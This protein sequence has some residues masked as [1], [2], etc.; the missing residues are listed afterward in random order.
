MIKR[1]ALF[2]FLLS[3]SSSL[4][5]QQP[6]IQDV[7][8]RDNSGTI[9]MLNFEYGFQMPGGDLKDRFGNY[10]GVGGGFELLLK[11]NISIS[12]EGTLHFGRRVKEDVL[13]E[14]RNSDSLFISNTRLLADVQLRQR[15]LYVGASV[16]KLWPVWKNNRR[17]GIKT[18]I[19]LGIFQHKIRI[20]SDPETFVPL[21]SGEY[22]KGYDRLSN[23]LSLRE[24]IGYQHFSRNRLINFY[25]G[26]EF[27][28][29]FT[30][31]RR[32][33]DFATRSTDTTQRT[34]LLWG[35]KV[36]WILPFYINE[37]PSKIYY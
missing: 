6:E 2:I 18:S 15:A 22:L 7:G 8:G 19:G 14:L 37:D 13:Q 34:D 4:L 33:F 1:F 3:C 36:G 21:L 24:F 5:A 27:T 12:L 9:F 32:D 16:G 10:N 23:G 30:Q 20:Q 29:A 31:N 28:Q 35:V 17:S 25:A 11:N 26:F